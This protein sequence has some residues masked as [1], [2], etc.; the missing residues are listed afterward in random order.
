MK[1]DQDE[2][3][4]EKGQGLAAE[5]MSRA[6]ST[7]LGRIWCAGATE[8]FNPKPSGFVFCSDDIVREKGLPGTPGNKSI[9]S[10][11]SGMAKKKLIVC[12][13]PRVRSERVARHA[14]PQQLWMK[15]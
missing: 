12:V 15:V 6:E 1:D 4:F 13:D 5:G 8:W 2:F 9:G 14:G 3:N 10:W 7:V 11:F